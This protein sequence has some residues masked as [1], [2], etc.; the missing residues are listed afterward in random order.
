MRSCGHVLIQSD[1]C[2]TRRKNEDTDNSQN[3]DHVKTQGEDGQRQ[4]KRRDLR[5]KQPC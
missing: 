3:E 2:P 4:A 1:W 5:K